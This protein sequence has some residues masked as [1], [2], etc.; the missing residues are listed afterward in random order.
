MGNQ[1]KKCESFK[2]Q[3]A[4]FDRYVNSYADSE[5]GR[6]NLQTRMEGLHTEFGKFKEIQIELDYESFVE[7][8]E[9]FYN[10]IAKAKVK[11]DQFKI[12]IPQPSTEIVLQD[13]SAPS[14]SSSYQH[15][16]IPTKE[17][18]HFSGNIEDWAKF[19]KKNRTDRPFEFQTQK[20]TEAPT[21]KTIFTRRSR[22]C[23]PGRRDE[24]RSCVEIPRR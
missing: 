24:L 10:A 16:V 14:T 18:P 11:Q 9:Q 8:T 23:Y 20:H 1:V 2:R 7:I 22:R 3:I 19:K 13:S 12:N 6:A 5:I 15:S 21:F 17:I 4:D